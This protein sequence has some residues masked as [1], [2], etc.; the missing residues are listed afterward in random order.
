[1][2]TASVFERLRAMGDKAPT[3]YIIA[4]GAGA[5]LA[6]AA[7]DPPGASAYL[8]GVSLPYAVEE[9]QALLGFKP[10]KF[11]SS[12]TAVDLA[13]AAYMKAWRPG[14]KAVGLGMTCSVASLCEH[15]GDH[16][17]EACVFTDDGCWTTGDIL[18]KAMGPA[19]RYNDDERAREM[20]MAL[21]DLALSD[22]PDPLLDCSAEAA[23]RLYFHPLFNADG[24]RT[25]A[26]SLQA[27]E[28]VL[29]PGAFNPPHQGHFDGGK[30]A[31]RAMAASHKQHRDVVYAL[32]TDPPHKPALTVAQVL[33]RACMMRGHRLLVS[34]GDP[35][36]IDKARRFPGAAIAMGADAMDR[37]LDPSWGPAI[38]PM[39]DEFAALGTRFLV[40]PRRVGDEVL[41]PGRVISRRGYDALHRSALF[42]PVDFQCDISS[43]QLREAAKGKAP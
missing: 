39:L 5:A 31:L 14:R 35:L 7:W 3:L 22:D 2:E 24:T 41:T 27:K 19:A 8:T 20:A 15:R 42:T 16:R 6:G 33:Q 13:L 40:N 4:T 23:C 12:E 29:F 10:D 36:Y 11:V 26:A 28:T 9:T 43:T 30:A 18:T 32:V 34:R 21:L 25:G 1:M 38:G 37:M 17:V